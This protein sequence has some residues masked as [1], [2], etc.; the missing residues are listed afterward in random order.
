MALHKNTHTHSQAHQ[1][2]CS[3]NS[4]NSFTATHCSCSATNIWPDRELTYRHCTF[5]ALPPRNPKK[6]HEGNSQNNKKKTE[7]VQKIIAQ[8]IRSCDS[9]RLITLIGSAFGEIWNFTSCRKR[10]KAEVNKE[11]GRE[12]F[13]ARFRVFSGE[14]KI[15]IKTKKKVFL[16]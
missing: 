8:L 9:F 4:V 3:V 11:K 1:Y 7:V 16:F 14:L 5:R 15:I 2:D 13:M 10:R 6:K 12:K